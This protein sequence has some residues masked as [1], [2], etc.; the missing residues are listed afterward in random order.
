MTNKKTPPDDPCAPAQPD[1]VL[2][3]ILHELVEIKV[4]LQTQSAQMAALE[5]L[6]LATALVLP[7]EQRL[8]YL[9]LATALQL[10]ALASGETTSAGLM[11]GTMDRWKALCGDA[12]QEP[13]AQQLLSLHTESLLLANVPK[14][15]KHAQQEW[16]SIATPE[17]I[18]QE[19]AEKLPARP[20]AGGVVPAKRLRPK[21]STPGGVKRKKKPDGE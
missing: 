20:V 6:V 5:R 13:L 2:S 7:V 15:L 10:N 21:K 8:E 9:E 1:G 16:L 19:L 4:S 14:H 12:L 11:T 17:E 18:A 3:Y